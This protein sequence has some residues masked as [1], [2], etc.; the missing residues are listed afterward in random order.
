M[1]LLSLALVSGALLLADLPA[2]QKPSPADEPIAAARL[3]ADA[4]V[5]RRAL[6]ELH[7]GL[8][9]YNTSAQPEGHFAA[10]SVFAAKLGCGH[11]FPNPANQTKASA[12]ALFGGRRRVPFEFRWID[13]RMILTMNPSAEP[14][15]KPG[16]EVIAIDG[17][18]VSTILS[19]LLT[20]ARADG[21]NDAKR[22]AQLGVG[23]L[24]RYPA[25][26]VWYPLFFPPKAEGSTGAKDR[27]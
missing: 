4:A 17:V 14:R 11:T 21:S 18:P 15:L 12:E 3:Q 1:P 5:L 2:A 23:S 6:E 9:R 24:D 8:H 19:T 13:R 10:L 25:F 22:I 26:D 20:I 16:A 27:R 7:P